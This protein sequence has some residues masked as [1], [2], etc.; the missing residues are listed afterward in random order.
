[1]IFCGIA[2]LLFSILFP[3]ELLERIIIIFLIGTVLSLEMLN[4]QLERALDLFIPEKDER[5]RKIKDI[6]SGAVL[7]ISFTSLVILVII[8]LSKIL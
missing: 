5:V 6:S 2:A 4:S 7:V 1:M 8:V 3:L